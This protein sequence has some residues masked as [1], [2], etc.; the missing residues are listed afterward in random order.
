[1]EDFKLTK[2]PDLG[3]FDQRFPIRLESDPI[4]DPA[5]FTILTGD[6][7]IL[8]DLFSYQVYNH[9]KNHWRGAAAPTDIQDGMIW[10]ETG[11]DKLYHEASGDEEILQLT[12][13]SD[14]S[15]YFANLYLAEY[16]YHT[17]DLDTYIRFQTDHMTL[18]VGNVDFIN[19]VETA[20]IDYL[21]LLDGLNF[22][23][24]D[25]NTKMTVGLTINQGGYDDEI[26]ALKSS[27]VG[28][29]MSDLAEIDTYG[30]FK[31]AEATA[32]GLSIEGYTEATA[33]LN[34]AGFYTTANTDKNV[35][36]V[37]AVNIW[38]LERSG[39]GVGNSTANSNIVAMKTRRGGAYEAVWVLGED[40][41]TWQ[42]GNATMAELISSSIQRIITTPTGLTITAGGA[43]TVTRSY[44]TVDGAG[45]V[46]DNLDTIN[47]GVAGMKLTLTAIDDATTI[48][49]RDGVGNI[50][51]EGGVN[52]AMGTRRAKTYLFYDAVEAK[53]VERGR[54]TG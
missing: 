20:G 31:K 39:A 29:G 12:R 46:G 41:A 37:G 23:G 18:K 10:S 50:E 17:G 7:G 27:D 35:N 53:W 19:M 28:H 15:P 22:I 16:L 48:T 9:I 54:F 24:D 4:Y 49:I 36:A 32:G 21:Q 33:A 44:H 34:I 5:K 30:S 47:G 40:G 51:L 43:I 26:F 3:I 6:D 11:T 1:M 45:G 38:G 25:I 52:H 8:D 42:D 13:S 2:K 14:V